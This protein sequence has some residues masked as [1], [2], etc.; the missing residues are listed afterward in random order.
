MYQRRDAEQLVIEGFQMPFGGHLS[1]QNRWVKLAELMPW[2][3]I[4][5]IYA[6]SMSQQTGR[7]ALSARIAFGAIF[8]KESENLTDEGTVTAIQENPYMQYFL[9]LET[10]QTR[11]LFDPSMMVHFRRRFP[12]EQV[13]KINEF[14][15]TGIWPEEMR[16]VD[17]DDHDDD[18]QKPSGGK[19]QKGKKKPNTARK[20]QKKAKK[21]RGKLILDA[22][23]APA[24]IKYP[25]DIDLL[26]QCRQ[27]IEQA[28]DLLWDHSR[29]TGHKLPYSR[30]HA[31]KSY[32]NLTKSKKWT[33]NKVRKA[34]G[35]QLG[36]IAK[37]R[38]RL[39]QLLLQVPAKLVKFPGWL[40][41]RLAVIPL[42][43][44]Q[45]KNMFDTR[46]HV[47]ENRIVSLQQPH[48]RPINRGKR[49]I[50]TEFGQKLH[51]SVVDGYTF[52]EQTSWNNFNEGCDLPCAVEEYHRRFGVYPEAVLAD[53]IYQTRANRNYCQQLGIRLSGPAL[54]RK[55]VG[56]QAKERRQIYRDSCRRNDIEGR[57]GNLKRRF[58]L[59][60]IF[61]KL[62]KNAKTE[63]ALNI[64]AM[65]A[66]RRLYRWLMLFFRF[67]WAKWVFQ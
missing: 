3:H 36:W 59:N 50:A 25:T 15:C 24:D 29:R 49:P 20:K 10:F 52:L 57:T 19:P 62:D 66:A 32:L 56:T 7:T 28:V 1:A 17:R 11:P 41:D 5:E 31:R 2:E 45:Q 63:A 21:N 14:V 9:G 54:G 40:W 46:T 48:I 61:S 64:L 38:V 53:R 65:N 35:E 12:V 13:A 47:C 42:V 8:I 22:T 27:H 18:G 33:A 60:L 58:G 26:N 51:L 34:I 44:A 4:E 55:R 23:V 16:Q 39:N 37:A 6:Q 43:F 67:F 30:K